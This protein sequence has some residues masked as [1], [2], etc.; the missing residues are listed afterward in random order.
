MCTRNL[1]S[2]SHLLCFSSNLREKK[3]SGTN[4]RECNIR[5]VSIKF[6]SSC[7]QYVL[8]G[9]KIFQSRGCVS[10]GE[11]DTTFQCHVF[12]STLKSLRII[13]YNAHQ[14]SADT[15]LYRC[16]W[17]CWSH[18]I[19][20]SALLWDESVI[21]ISDYVVNPACIFPWNEPIWK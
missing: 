8:M 6:V 4:F 11:A 1:W 2:R 21:A 10:C 9:L 14:R 5:I 19:K 18:W 12:Y 20:I 17:K 15:T 13:G 7:W 16:I 3:Y